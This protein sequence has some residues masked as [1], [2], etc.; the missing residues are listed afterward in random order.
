MKKYLIKIEVFFAIVALVDF[1]F[2]KV[3]DYL[4]DHTNGGFSG[5]VHYI[6]EESNEDII[7]MGSSRMK[8][9]YVPQVFE[10][11]LGMTC[12]NAGIDGNGIIM[13]YGFL[14][15]ILQRYTPKMII[16]DV[17]RFD[18]YKDDNTKYLGNLRAYYDKHGIPAIFN[19]VDASERWKMLSGLYRYNSSL[20]GL[21]GD[22]FHP[23]QL[24]DKG[25]W[26]GN[27]EMNYEPEKPRIEDNE[28]D[29]L[30]MLYIEKYIDLATHHNI[31]LVFCFSP[32]YFGE[33]M[34]NSNNPVK[35]ICEKRNVPFFDYHYETVLCGDRSYW[36]DATHLNHSGAK[37]Y[38]SVLAG[39]IKNIPIGQDMFLPSRYKKYEN[40]P[41]Q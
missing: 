11:S 38:S 39:V 12:Y 23:V 41:N 8:H 18:M 32:T 6:C 15:M 2:G 21:V 4:R 10:D 17:S 24:F 7:M 1:A 14:E 3:C 26:R 19:D 40:T 31:E 9:H 22:N 25:Y 27:K 16:Y 35:S 36:S 20:L 34:N 5:N 28:V 13:S 30:K 33:L 29:S 37:Y